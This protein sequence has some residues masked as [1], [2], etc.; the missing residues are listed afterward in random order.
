MLM[1][2]NPAGNEEM[3]ILSV[4][5]LFKFFSRTG[6]PMPFNIL[7][8]IFFSA[9]SFKSIMMYSEAGFGNILY[10]PL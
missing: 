9:H 10:E 5:L 7:I 3:S 2:Y 6:L 1:R 8:F 4:A